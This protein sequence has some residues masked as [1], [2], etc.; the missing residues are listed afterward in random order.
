[1]AVHGQSGHVEDPTLSLGSYGQFFSDRLANSGYTPLLSGT[2]LIAVGPASGAEAVESLV[3]AIYHRFGIFMTSIDE[4][5]VAFTTG[6][7]GFGSALVADFA[8]RSL[9]LPA[10]HPGWLGVYPHDGQ[11][12]VAIDFYSDGESP[13]PAS[14]S[15]RVGYPVSAQVEDFH[16][17]VVQSFT[18]SGPDGQPIASVL[19]S[20]SPDAQARDTH[21]P[22][23]AAAILP[24]APLAYGTKYTASFLGT[25]NGASV[26]RTWTFT[27]VQPEIVLAPSSV[28]VAPGST[29]TLKVA[30]G[31]GRYTTQWK[32]SGAAS[33]ISVS[34]HGSETL[35][36][37][38]IAP[39]EAGLEILDADGHG[40]AVAVTVIPGAVSIPD[41]F[42]YRPRTG[43]PPG[44]PAVSALI[45]ITGINVPAAVS[46]A[47]GEYSINGGAYTSVPGTLQPGDRVGARSAAPSG[48]GAEGG[49]LVTVG[50]VSAQF[51]VSTHPVNEQAVLPALATG[52]NLQGNGFSAALDPTDAFG[53][54]ALPIPGVSS[55]IES[56]WAWNATTGKWQFYSPLLTPA[57]S[58]QYASSRGFEELTTIAPG[59]GYWVYAYAPV[60]LPPQSGEPVTYGA[61]WF[62][63]LPTGWNLIAAGAPIAP[64]NL[65][66]SVGQ[67]PVNFESLWA[68]DAAQSKWYF[69]SP[70]LDAM[71]GGAANVSAY[72]SQHDLLDFGAAGKQLAPG[73]GFWVYRR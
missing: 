62:D 38:G 73:E 48:Y 18:L 35:V 37:T 42:A 56:V 47:G 33:P 71:A 4:Q 57:Q 51:V 26:A 31:N 45:P 9:P 54:A 66:S 34:F 23:S 70:V 27:T 50:G 58:A 2:E 68:W 67:S 52:W 6:R 20:G 43:V 16:N 21:L 22:I 8:S 65:N 69:H 55:L 53:H 24:L 17:L 64:A 3:Q 46:I 10:P 72:A 11:T 28:S 14:G 29:A 41:A 15:N 7:P 36:I 60:M 13:D 12:G 19:L 25:S 63:S 61:Q 5:G 1:M 30:G 39:G 44:V 49:A 59:S 40:A 32:Y